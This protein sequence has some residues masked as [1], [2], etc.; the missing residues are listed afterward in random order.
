MTPWWLAVVVFVVVFVVV[1]VVGFVVVVLTVAVVLCFSSYLS[2][3]L[4]GGDACW[5]ET[6]ICYDP[7]TSFYLPRMA[8][9]LTAL[10]NPRPARL[11]VL[12]TTVC[13]LL[14][15]YTPCFICFYATGE[16]VG[17]R[18]PDAAELDGVVHKPILP[19]GS[20]LQLFLQ[21]LPPVC[22]RAPPG[23]RS[24]GRGGG[25]RRR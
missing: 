24:M 17:G 21:A 6:I 14:L 9:S 2:L 12:E 1:D 3:S 23:A 22:A 20:G 18:E 7:H 16:G 11:F 13:F 10:P 19:G 5:L 8:V 15:T 25:R 4:S